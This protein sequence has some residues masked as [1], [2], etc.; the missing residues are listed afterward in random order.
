MEPKIILVDDEPELLNLVRDYLVREGFN[1]LTETN[2]IEGLRRIEREKP[3]LVLLDW[4]LPG[5]SGIEIC[6]KLRQTSSIPIIMLTARSEEVDRILGLEFGADDYVVKPFSL[7]ELLARIRTVLRRTLSG[8]QNPNDGV[9]HRGELTVDGP[10]HR[11]WKREVEIQLT[12][13]EFKILQLLAS[14][15]GVAY[16][17]LQLLREAMGEEYLYYERSI[18]THVSN[19]RRKVE[20]NPAEPI[21]ILTVFGVGYRF[22][23]P[24]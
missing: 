16:S 12:P 22:G 5:M 21:Y 8:V 23:E 7:R 13:T 20:D 9:I 15:P 24:S 4:M 11:V 10:S 6:K 3:D 17:R 14:R 19:L 1:V 2:G 18:D